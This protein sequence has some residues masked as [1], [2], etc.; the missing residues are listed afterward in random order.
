MKIL[1]ILEYYE[2]HIG[3]VETLFKQLAEHLSEHGH[4]ITVVTNQFERSLPKS[5]TK[6][7]LTIIR[8]PF[9]NRYLFTFLSFFACYKYARKHDFIHTTSYN[10]GVPAFLAGL[11]SNKKTIITFHEV[12][13]KLWFSLPYTNKILQSL[14]FVFERMLLSLP[15]NHF[16]AVS[17]DTKDQLIKHGIPAKKISMIYNGIQYDQFKNIEP[18]PVKN[19]LFRFIYF[20]RLGISKGL[21]KLLDAVSKLKAN[22]QKEFILDLVIPKEPKSFYN[23]MMHIVDQLNIKNQVNVIH[24]LSWRDL[25]SKV[26]SS[27]AVVIPSYSE[28][29]CFTAVESMA[30]E[31]P[32]ISSGKGALSEVVHGKLIE[33]TPHT[34]EALA[35]SMSD[36]MDGKWLEKETKMFSIESSVQKYEELYKKYI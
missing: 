15:F 18:D 33:F 22:T 35:G 26:K 21:D 12:W 25:L 17:N 31:V 27:D 2:P 11:L 36:A 13:G 29:F 28:G 7:N 1:Y 4:E 19:E 34:S 10:A 16:V 14:F 8:L 20:G 30:L 6:A 32:I 3:G 9:R 5:E 24:H 23:K